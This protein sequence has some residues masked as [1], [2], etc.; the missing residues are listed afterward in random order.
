MSS[1][2]DVIEVLPARPTREGAGVKLKRA[3]GYDQ[4]PRFDPF[5]LLDDIHST[6]PQDYVAGFP[7]HPIGA[8]RPSPT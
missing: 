2:R 7:W 1:V 5:L 8:S 6:D 3:V 4:V